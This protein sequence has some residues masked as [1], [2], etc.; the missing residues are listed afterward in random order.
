M[1]IFDYFIG[2]HRWA[3]TYHMTLSATRKHRLS[4]ILKIRIDP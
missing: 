4:T 2:P 1:F 3:S